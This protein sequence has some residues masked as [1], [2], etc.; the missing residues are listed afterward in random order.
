MQFN[1]DTTAG[2]SQSSS[3]APLAANE[4]HEV[5]FKGLELKE[6]NGYKMIIA[7]FENEKGKFQKTFFE[8]KEADFQ[9]KEY[10]GD[11]GKTIYPSNVEK[12]MLTFKHLIDAVNPELGKKIDSKEKSLNVKSWDELRQLMVKATEPGV[13]TITNIKLMT[14]YKGEPDF[15]D[16]AIAV[17]KE[18]KAFI[19]SNFIGEKLFFNSYEI[20]T[21]N[22]KKDAKP[23][24]TTSFNLASEPTAKESSTGLDFDL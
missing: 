15:S 21:I 17:T 22:T 14:N 1:F 24:A 18:G 23:T 2:S 7:R 20:K 12:M 11:K 6:T 8:P 9:R 13:D 16:R 4:V 5:T 19:G 10:D 3:V